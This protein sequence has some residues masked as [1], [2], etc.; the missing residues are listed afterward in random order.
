MAEYMNVDSDDENV[1]LP[2]RIFRERL[3]PMDV[4]TD[5]ELIMNYRFDRRTI[6]DLAE[7]VEEDLQPQTMRNHA[8]LP[9]MQILIALRFFA[10]G[11]FHSVLAE[12]FHVHFSTVSRVVYRVARALCRKINRFIKFPDHAE[13]NDF[14]IR[15]HAIA[16]FPRVCGAIDGTHIRIQAPGEHEDTFVNRKHYHSINVQCICDPDCKITNIVASW[17]G[18]THDSRILT[19][20]AICRA[21]ESGMHRGLLIGDSGYPCRQW[22]MTPFMNPSTP[23]K[24]S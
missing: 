23:A 12:V 10:C 15:F 17:P 2:K 5:Q 24:V 22:L 8:L 1:V 9:V 20:S 21:F 14:A 19:E 6:Y 3:N 11:T 18:S 4:L 16:G 7:M 13:Q